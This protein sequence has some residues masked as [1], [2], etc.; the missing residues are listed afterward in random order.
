LVV[1]D[2]DDNDDAFVL[3]VDELSLLIRSSDKEFNSVGFPCVASA[4]GRIKTVK[5]GKF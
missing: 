2:E 4:N 1:V 3:V 5:Y